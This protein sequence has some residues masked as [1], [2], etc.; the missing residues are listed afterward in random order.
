[1]TSDLRYGCNPH[2]G[3]ASVSHDAGPLR[4]RNGAA[5]YINLLDAMNNVLQRLLSK[6]HWQQI[7]SIYSINSR[8]TK[9]I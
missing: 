6:R 9:M 2:Q 8:P 3:Q 4:V 1:M 5:S 7:M